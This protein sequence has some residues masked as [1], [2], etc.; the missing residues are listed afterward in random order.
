VL[1]EK[2]EGELQQDIKKLIAYS[3]YKLP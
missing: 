3:A 1:V 2:W